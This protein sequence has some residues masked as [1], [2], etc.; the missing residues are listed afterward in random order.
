MRSYT[1]ITT[2]HRQDVLL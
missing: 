1:V 2:E